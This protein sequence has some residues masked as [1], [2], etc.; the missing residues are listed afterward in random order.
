VADAPRE[1]QAPVHGNVA[2]PPPAQ[3]Q[4]GQGQRTE[5]QQ[6][7]NGNGNNGNG[8]GN[9]QLAMA[10]AMSRAKARKVRNNVLPV[11]RIRINSSNTAIKNHSIRSNSKIRMYFVRIEVNVARQMSMVTTSMAL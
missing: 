7:G 6:H 9:G 1:R 8:N 4:E 5:G 11:I 3:R 10:M 2:T